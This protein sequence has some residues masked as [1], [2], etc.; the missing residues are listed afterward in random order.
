MRQKILLLGGSYGQIPAIEEAKRRALFTILC[1]YL[2]DNPGKDL[3]DE[4]HLVS[5]TDKEK[6]LEVAK[7]NE[8]D[9]IWAY[10][11]DPAA[12][13]AAHVAREMGLFG[14]PPESVELLSDKGLFRRFQKLNE[15]KT[16]A[17]FVLQ[18]N[19]IASL[20]VENIA[21]ILPVVVK[22][23]D[24][25]DTKG[26]NRVDHKNNL[27]EAVKN[28]LKYSR[29]GKVIVEE[30]I[31]SSMGRLHGDAFMVDG[32]M[33]FCLLGDQFCTSGVAPL[34]PSCTVFP[35]TVDNEQMKRV[36]SIVGDLIKKSGYKNGPV[37]VEVRINDRHDIYVMELG[38]RSGG[39]LTPESILSYTGFDMLKAQ[40]DQIMGH[41]PDISPAKNGCVIRF[42]L[43]SEVHGIFKDYTIP[44][45]LKPFVSKYELF[46]K[47]DEEVKPM[48]YP[49][50]NIGVLI[51]KF[52]SP[53]AVPDKTTLFQKLN[54]G[55]SIR[56]FS[57]TEEEV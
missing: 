57:K 21:S 47:R 9:F 12:L 4:F 13:T 24:S 45:D 8:V 38:P 32:E 49:G 17:Y 3:A 55:L 5:T 56:E 28:A 29:S 51:L 16:P 11:S 50:S 39:I 44:W 40:I 15:F 6:V 54:E 19:E 35:S 30:F 20:P 46:V 10:A 1:D 43:C 18:E 48:N 53:D 22:P 52:D 23:V 2:P 33:K 37:N 27:E 41:E 42:T 34:K 25:S 14:N 26:V 7:E 36:E 31:D